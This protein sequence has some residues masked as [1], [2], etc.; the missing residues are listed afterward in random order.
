MLLAVGS[1]VAFRLASQLPAVLFGWHCWASSHQVVN[2][3]PL[4]EVEAQK[5]AA[6]VLVAVVGATAPGNGSAE[7]V[8]GLSSLWSRPL[9]Q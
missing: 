9:N 7:S 3:L 5:E 8:L 2:Q 1:T 4:G 6:A